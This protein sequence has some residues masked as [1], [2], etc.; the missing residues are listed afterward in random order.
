LN[1]LLNWYIFGSVNLG[2]SGVYDIM[3]II[4]ISLKDHVLDDID[5]LQQALGFSGRSEFI[6]AAVQSLAAVEKERAGLSGIVTGVAIA[7]FAEKHSDETV[8]I[9]H[10]YK[11]VIR[12]QIH[13]H[14]ESGKCLYI[15]ILKGT[16]KKV[17]DLVHM[18]MK[19]RHNE[20]VKLF[21]A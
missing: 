7:V 16:A 8:D 19:A 20:F 13:E 11:D 10:V 17:T 3:P 6:R 1:Y 14:I 5:Q 12:T 21:V 18:L 2:S 4:S 9:M 15:F